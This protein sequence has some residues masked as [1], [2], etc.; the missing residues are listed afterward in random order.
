MDKGHSM[1]LIGTAWDRL[2][3]LPEAPQP[4]RQGQGEEQVSSLLMNKTSEAY[5][6]HFANR[7]V[8]F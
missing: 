4:T 3:D 7:H 6:S 5:Q 1:F 8:S 2:H